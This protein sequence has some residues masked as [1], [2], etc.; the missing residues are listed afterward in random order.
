MTNAIHDAN[1]QLDG[2][3]NARNRQ[4]P[5][6]VEDSLEV[7]DSLL[8][9]EDDYSSYSSGSN[10]AGPD[11][12]KPGLLGSWEGIAVMLFGVG[13]PAAVISA[14]LVTCFDRVVRLFLKH[15]AE[16]LVE[17]VLALLIPFGNYIVWSALSRNEIRNS[18]RRGV[19]NGLSLGSALIIA[20]I[21][22]VALVLG[23]PVTETA[24]GQILSGLYMSCAV[25]AWLAFTTSF[26]LADRLRR[27][28]QT[29]G[30][31]ARSI[32]FSAIGV[33]L[34]V[35]G[36][37]AS[38]AQSFAVRYAE[39]LAISESRDD[40]KKG[41]EILRSLK[42][43][44]DIK[45][46]CADQ[47]CAGIAGMFFLIN[48]AIE[49]QL[50]FAVSG[51]PFRDQESTDFASLPDDYLS[52][53]VVGAP[54]KGLG[55]LRS[56]I[57]GTVSPETLTSTL[58]WEMVLK[59]RTYFPQEARAEFMLPPNA[60]VSGLTLWINGE[61]H[62]AAFGR[63]QNVR[64]AYRWV[65]GARRDPALI[66]DLGRGRTL[67]QCA[68]VPPQGEM[69]VRVT[70]T[71]PLKLDVPSEAVLTLPRFIDTNFS[72][73]GDHSVGVRSPLALKLKRDGVRSE[74]TVN[75][76]S[77]LTGWLD[78]SAISG[79]GVSVRV[80]RPVTMGPIAVR[81]PRTGRY[82]IETIHQVASSVPKNLVIALDGSQSMKEHL[83]EIEKA[84][85]GIPRSI[86]TSVL[87]A[88]HSDEKAIKPLPLKEGL[89]FMRKY[90]FS[91]GRDNLL[92]VVKAAEAAGE[93]EDG[94]VLW[95]HGPQPAYNHEMYIMT[96]FSR[97]PRFFELAL[98]NGLTNA[99][100]FFKNH[101]EIGPFVPV[102]R[103]GKVSEDLDRLISKWRL[104]GKEYVTRFVETNQKP[105]SRFGNSREAVELANLHA[106]NL[107]NRYINERNVQAAEKIAVSSRLVTLVSGAVVLE[108]HS[109]YSRWGLNDPNQRSYSEE[110]AAQNAD[111]ALNE[112]DGSRIAF[113]G[114]SGAPVLQSATNG[115]IGPQGA[116][117]TVITGINTAGTVR[118]NNLANLEALL[119]VIA[120][121][122]QIFG[123][124][125]GGF[126]VVSNLVRKTGMTM[127]F[128]IPV[129]MSR[130]AAIALGA[131]LFFIGLAFPGLINYMVASARDANLFD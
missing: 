34:A 58:H 102:T 93:C 55:L 17:I 30:S 121:G 4:S 51:K 65:T 120:N 57:T 94:A 28:R 37:S 108:R 27:T 16:S 56:G 75:G 123:I 53:H 23:S 54:I 127:L 70:M 106:F 49:R 42:P 81:D 100:E 79:T 24:R 130:P 22:T 59:N 71:S 14:G 118:V 43:E 113:D 33:A 80:A 36:F 60:V 101:K 21:P 61:P 47:K 90:D 114:A 1:T 64:G 3:E 92:T 117:A 84:L 85:K 87:I 119:N 63:P 76:D 19:I 97:T 20:L 2:D 26:Y 91:G 72:L 46:Q 78:E 31:Q 129:S 7:D 88:T 52:R 66:T 18:I 111:T 98:D 6:E 105:A 39:Q 112:I 50:Y 13:L 29:S 109:D 15:P 62:N 35:L 40:I 77:L 9:H 104:G 103:N 5:N 38:E 96:P 44:R 68:P 41:L 131:T 124:L 107:V 86:N 128:G 11:L 25:I 74:R 12:L 8:D 32:V 116:D 99:G 110:L 10:R 95:I 73:K 45:M 48:P 126:L 89:E 69:K 115:S 82:L 67:L 125:I 122:A 83:S